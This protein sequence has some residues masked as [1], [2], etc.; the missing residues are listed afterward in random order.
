MAL[1]SLDLALFQRLAEHISEQI[2]AETAALAR[3]S[4]ASFD[5]YRY[6][7]GRIKG[8]REALEYARDANREILGLPK[9]K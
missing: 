5:D 8:L 1:H 4:S 3:G 7:V 6:R 2:E 9:E